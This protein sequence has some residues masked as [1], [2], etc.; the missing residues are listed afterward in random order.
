MATLPM[1]LSNP[2]YSKPP[3]F[4]QFALPFMSSEQVIIETSNLVCGLNTASR[5]LQ[6]TNLPEMGGVVTSSDPV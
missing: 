6:I 5:S 2:N 4:L 1:T 3:Q